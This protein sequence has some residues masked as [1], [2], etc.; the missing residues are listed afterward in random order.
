MTGILAQT[1]T[2]TSYGNEYLENGELTQMKKKISVFQWQCSDYLE[3]EI[4]AGCGENGYIVAYG[5]A[6]CIRFK[7]ASAFFCVSVQ[8]R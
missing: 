3:A 7:A 5:H 6:N 4:L 8:L 1:I 2:L